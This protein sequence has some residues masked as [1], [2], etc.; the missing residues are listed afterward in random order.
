M[1]SWEEFGRGIPELDEHRLLFAF[2]QLTG[3]R[4]FGDVPTSTDTAAAL[5]SVA[6]EAR[7]KTGAEARLL[8]LG[9][10]FAEKFGVGAGGSACVDGG[11]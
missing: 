7:G 3:G 6:A 4:Y 1:E 11:H 8:P 9:K 5:K 2:T 10:W